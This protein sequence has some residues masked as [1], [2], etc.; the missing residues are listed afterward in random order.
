[1]PL[2]DRERGRVSVWPRRTVSDTSVKVVDGGVRLTRPGKPTTPSVAQDVRG[3]G[4]GQGLDECRLP[5]RTAMSVGDV[6]VE[7]VAIGGTRGFDHN[8]VG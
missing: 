7:T 1:M 2:R 4:F 6:S 3:D 5:V 8:D